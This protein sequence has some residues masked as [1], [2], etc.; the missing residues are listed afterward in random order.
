MLVLLWFWPLFL[1]LLV[2]CF[3]FIF[4]VAALRWLL[5]VVRR[6]SPS[7]FLVVGLISFCRFVSLFSMLC[8]NVFVDWPWFYFLSQAGI[9]GGAGFVSLSGPVVPSSLSAVPVVPHYSRFWVSCVCAR[10]FV[11][12][13]M[14]SGFS[15]WGSFVF[16]LLC[17]WLFFIM[18]SLSF[19]SVW[20]TAWY[21]EVCDS[22]P[23]LRFWPKR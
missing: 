19:W 15:F 5:F 17:Y 16:L 4:L 13:S 18:L 20:F 22:V 1:G 7:R 11:A 23:L 14:V 6:W 12:A 21:G 2:L 8:Y 9:L 3:P 10:C